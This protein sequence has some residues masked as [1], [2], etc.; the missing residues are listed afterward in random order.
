M[1]KLLL[2]HKSSES[3]G[4]L[5]GLFKAREGLFLN[6]GDGLMM[7]QT[8]NMEDFLAFLSSKRY[9]RAVSLAGDPKAFENGLWEVY[10][11]ELK[12]AMKHMDEPFLTTYLTHFHSIIF[13]QEEIAYDE[14]AEKHFDQRLQD[15]VSLSASGSDFTKKLSAYAI[16]RFNITEAFRSQIHQ[17]E[18]YPFYAGGH[19]Q[20]EELNLLLKS[21]FQEIPKEL[22][23]THWHKF[24]EKEKA[25]KKINFDLILRFEYF[26]FDL[27]KKLL[28]D[29]LMHPYGLSYILAYF[30]YFMLEIESIKR[31]Y[32]CLKYDLPSYWMKESSVS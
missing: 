13:S 29:P 15:W 11:D 6:A 7:R 9:H 22:L 19:F 24:F 31:H 32:L 5:S 8:Q 18:E 10:F 20:Q 4:Y 27:L 16:D 25:Y 17:S 23:F 21:H 28:E 26:W 1:N 30:L 3:Y 12:M 14:M 2:H